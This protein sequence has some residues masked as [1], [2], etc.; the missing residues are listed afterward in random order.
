MLKMEGNKMKHKLILALVMSG[1]LLTACAQEEEAVKKIEAT[2]IKE[3]VQY[4]T[5]RNITAK[6][7]SITATQLV[8]TNDNEEKE[9]YELP[10]E[11]FF[12]SIAPYINETHPCHNHSLTGCQGELVKEEF[13]IYI[14]DEKGNVVVNET[15]QTGVNGFIDLWLLRNQTYQIKIQHG[16]KLVESEF[17]TF[18]KDGTCITTLQLT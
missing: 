18:D 14:E 2:E 10:K 5:A 4:Y 16:S 1:S 3:M 8:V 12:V 6:S 17:S 13:D 11:E 15:L 9:V 7:A